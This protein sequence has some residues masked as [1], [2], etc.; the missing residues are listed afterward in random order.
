[1]INQKPRTR[2][3]GKKKIKRV[4]T[5]WWNI[6]AMI[7]RNMLPHNFK[8]FYESWIY[9]PCMPLAF[10]MLLKSKDNLISF[11][12]TNELLNIWREY[13]NELYPM[14][15]KP[16]LIC[17]SKCSVVQDLDTTPIKEEIV[18]AIKQL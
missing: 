17:L 16:L 11:F 4:K 8:T 10:V 9:N 6:K 15:L 14:H 12:S 2:E 13:L 3:K 1:M 7:H 18:S 5:H